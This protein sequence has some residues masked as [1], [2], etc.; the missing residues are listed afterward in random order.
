MINMRN[1]N[2]VTHR[3]WLSCISVLFLI[4]LPLANHA[5]TVSHA[6]DQ[7]TSAKGLHLIEAM[8][9]K[10][11]AIRSHIGKPTI[12]VPN[13]VIKN[14]DAREAFYQ[15]VSLYQKSDRLAQ[16]IVRSTV[17]LDLVTIN[18]QPYQETVIAV[19]NA[20]MQRIDAVLDEL[21]IQSPQDSDG[22]NEG[23]TQQKQAT[24]SDLYVAIINTN[25][26]VNQLLD[27][28]YSPGD[29]YKQLTAAIHITLTLFDR[30]P[31]TPRN[32]SEP[33]YVPDKTP[34]DVFKLL[35]DCYSEVSSIAMLSKVDVLEIT[36]VSK[37]GPYVPSEV[38]DV[39]TLLASELKYIHDSV[40]GL[41]EVE[42][43][44]YPGR[45]YPSDV[46]QR[47]LLLKRMLKD[48]HHLI[49][50]NPNWHR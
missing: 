18:G 47:G 34:S 45:V 30:F 49:K 48:L 23:D 41:S 22:D 14:A 24:H 46:Y 13:I 36:S 35:I 32:F 10:L 19:I 31:E 17:P 16:E 40:S 3:T 4:T 1:C 15:A 25:Q 43:S 6:G 2:G 37:N 44:Y 12:E 26:H 11:E 8:H 5:Q 21:G 28:K 9:R 38:Y 33:K 50:D 29:V 20:A 39:A 42:D 27:N 7:N